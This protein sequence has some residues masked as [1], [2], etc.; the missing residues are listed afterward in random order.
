MSADCPK[1]CCKKFFAHQTVTA[2]I[3]VDQFNEFVENCSTTGDIVAESAGTPFGPYICH[4]CHEQ[5][6]ELPCLSE[7]DDGKEYCSSCGREM[8]TEGGHICETCKKQ[9][10]H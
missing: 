2:D 10:T 9:D 5:Y 4:D 3:I 6:D 1:C 8:I 7:E